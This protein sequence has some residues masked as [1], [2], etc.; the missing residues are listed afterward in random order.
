MERKGTVPV[1]VPCYTATTQASSLS[2]GYTTGRS[3]QLP[4]KPT[5]NV[6][7]PHLSAGSLSSSSCLRAAMTLASSPSPSRSLPSTSMSFSRSTQGWYCWACLKAACTFSSV[8]ALVSLHRLTQSTCQTQHTAR[9][10]QGGTAAGGPGD[11]VP[12]GFPLPIHSSEEI[13][14]ATSQRHTQVLSKTGT[15]SMPWHG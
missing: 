15:F 8:A 3:K 1:E 14:L 2:H 13:R 7:G 9:L 11:N 5:G 10:P 6:Q 12:H 4:W